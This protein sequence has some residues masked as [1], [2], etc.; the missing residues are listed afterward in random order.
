MRLSFVSL[1]CLALE[2]A[3]IVVNALP[4]FDGNVCAQHQAECTPPAAECDAA[5]GRLECV[6]THLECADTLHGCVDAATG[7][8]RQCRWYDGAGLCY[9]DGA[10]LWK[11]TAHCEAHAYAACTE[12]NCCSDVQAADERPPW[13]LGD[14]VYPCDHLVRT[15]HSMF[16]IT[17]GID[18][19]SLLLGGFA[20]YHADRMVAGMDDAEIPA[21][22]LLVAATPVSEGQP[23]VVVQAVA[24][25]DA[26]G[27]APVVVATTA[28]PL[29]ADA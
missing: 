9:S 11:R 3:H 28:N 7:K 13:P 21:P 17:L 14:C 27:P 22:P 1:C 6:D 18:L 25:Q 4:L 8:A 5:R 12:E 20:L 2:A 19:W 10:G 23:V 26:P 29:S 16:K 15:L 24:A